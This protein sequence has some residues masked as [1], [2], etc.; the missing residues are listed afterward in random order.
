MMV[1]CWPPFA[2][3]KTW[4]ASGI[5]LQARSRCRDW[6]SGVSNLGAVGFSPDG[7]QLVTGSGA[8]VRV[9]DVATG[10][11]L[12]DLHGQQYQSVEAVAFH[13]TAPLL[14]TAGFGL[15]K[16]WDLRRQGSVLDDAKDEVRSV[17]VTPNGKYF[18][19]GS[20]DGSMRIYDAAT[21][22]LMASWKGHSSTVSSI[23]FS[24]DSLDLASGSFD[25]TVKTWSVPYGKATHTFSGHTARV[26]S[27]A[28]S[29][30]GRQIVSGSED[31]TVRSWDLA[32]GA[33]LATIP[34]TGRISR[35]VFSPDGR[36][37]L[38]LR[39][40]DKSVLLW[41]ALSKKEC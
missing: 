13:P 32:A 16:E 15:I 35:V 17:A 25:K 30:D 22:R 39:M 38:A 1:G 8:V 40:Y 10:N 12:R 6:H 19:S 26:W 28:F 29:P 36:I 11:L 18:A 20:R 27:I 23:A 21:N 14:Y 4:C 24:P 5:L 33:S 9:W 2:K 7:S 37:L 34:A 41:D 31:Q 3:T